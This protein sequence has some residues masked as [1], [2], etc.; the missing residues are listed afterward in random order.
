VRGDAAGSRVQIAE[1]EAAGLAA[2]LP[3]AVGA[4]LARGLWW[5]VL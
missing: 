5:R 3:H 2:G 1:Q 4:G